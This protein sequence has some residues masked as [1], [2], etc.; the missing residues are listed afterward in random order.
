MEIRESEEKGLFQSLLWNRMV[1]S[2]K[3]LLKKL[4]ALIR[5]LALFFPSQIRKQ[6]RTIYL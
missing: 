1:S 5:I 3:V 6:A 2:L 4:K